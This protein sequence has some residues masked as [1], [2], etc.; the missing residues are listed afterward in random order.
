M[1]TKLDPLL[2]TLDSS[3]LEQLNIDMDDHSISL[4]I[5]PKTK[6][7]T[8]IRFDGVSAFYYIDSS[9]PATEAASNQLH[10]ITHHYRGFGEFAAVRSMDAPEEDP[11][12]VS[13]PNFAISLNESSLFIEATKVS[14][15]DQVFTVR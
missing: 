7:D 11:Y 15:D 9:E 6:K 13:I 10:S 14:I 1:I 5:L 12:M 8:K 4:D 2:S 3:A